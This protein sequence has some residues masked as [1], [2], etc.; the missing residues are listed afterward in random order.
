[1][2]FFLKCVLEVGSYSLKYLVVLR[3]SLKCVLEVVCCCLKC[4]SDVANVFYSKCVLEVASALEYQVCT[5]SRECCCVKR[6]VKI[7][8]RML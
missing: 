4:V 6:E 2:L 7:I 8:A 3:Y 1:M 5:I